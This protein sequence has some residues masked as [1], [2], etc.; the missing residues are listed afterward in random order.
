M[1]FRLIQ[2]N[3]FFKKMYL[4]EQHFTGKSV[5]YI[6]GFANISVTDLYIGAV[7][8]PFLNL[9][10]EWSVSLALL[11]ARV[12]STVGRSW[13]SLSTSLCRPR[14]AQIASCKYELCDS[15]CGLRCA[16]LLNQLGAGSFVAS[17]V[18]LPQFSHPLLQTKDN[19]SVTQS[20]FLTFRSQTF[21]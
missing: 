6:L 9:T 15:L 3:I 1:N 16:V 2:G 20:V 11:F 4:V 14:H 7:L 12:A 17:M 13:F 18:C 10:I 19:V 21:T 5:L 8:L